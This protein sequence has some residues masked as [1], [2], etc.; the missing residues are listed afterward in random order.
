[1][2]QKLLVASIATGLLLLVSVFAASPLSSGQSA[3]KGSYVSQVKFI[4]YLDENVALGEVKAGKLDTYFYRILPEV[5]SDVKNDS[6]IKIYER[7]A[8]SYGLLLN[9]APAKA[10][11]TSTLNPFQFKQVR[12]AMNYLVDRDFIVNEILRG[13]G[14][15]MVDPFG[16][17]SPEYLNVIGTVE[18]FGFRNDPALAE[19]MI[20]DALI[21][22]GATKD[23]NG[24][25]MFKGKPIT[26][27]ILIRSDDLK[28]KAI[29]ESLSSSL[30]NLGF[31]IQKDYGDLTKASGVVYGSDPQDFQW[32]IYTEGYAGTSAFVKYNPV[33]DAQMYGPWFGNLPG[34]QNTAFWQYQNS[35]LDQLTQKIYLANF[36]SKSERNDLVNAATKQ[37]IQESVRIFL[38]QTREPFVASSSLK[39]LVNDFGAGITSRYSLIN[40]R[41][42]NSNDSLSVGMKQIYQTAWNNVEGCKDTFCVNILAAVEDGSTTRHPYTGEILPLRNTWNNQDI[43]TRGPLSKLDV[44]PDAQI[45]DPYSEQWKAVGQNVTSKSK[46]TYT[47]LYS[48]WHNGIMMDKNDLLYSYYFPFEWSKKNGTSIDPEYAAQA[49]VGIPLIKGIKFLADDKYVSYLD[50]WHYDSKEIADQSSVWSVEPWEITAATERLVKDGKIA[51]SKSQATAKNVDWLSLIVVQHAN[52]IKDELQNMK[53]EGF[54][55]LALKGLVSV[56]DARK[57]YDASISWIQQ[58]QNAL[59]SNG[60]F[61]LDNYNPSGGTITIKAFRDD[62]YP[63]EQGH[64]SSFENPKLATIQNV[65]VPNV[66][67]IGQPST[68]RAN[69][70][71]NGQPSNDAMVNY[72]ISNK[73]GVVVV[74]GLAQPAS[75]P[76][77]VG[78]FAATVQAN[79]TSKLSAG[80]NVLKLFAYGNEALK[81]D[82]YSSTILAAA[83]TGTNNSGSTN[84]NNSST[85]QSQSGSSQTKTGQPSRCLIATAA[86]GSDLAPEVQYLRNFRENY[87]LNTK[88]G[89]AF[90]NT[91]NAVYYSFSPQV[92]DYE[93]G[94]PWM[95]QTVRTALY[96]LFGILALSEKAHSSVNGGEIGAVFAGVV[97]SSLIATVY[98]APVTSFVSPLNRRFTPKIFKIVLSILAATTIAMICGIFAGNNLSLLSLSTAAF[99]VAIAALST[100]AV[101]KGIVILSRSQKTRTS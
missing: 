50:F 19:K 45:W 96:P 8:G 91:F 92:A 86:F 25:W 58:H 99:V 67:T 44:Q 72:F 78:Q 68:I 11:D 29:G 83:L 75:S 65:D 85:N 20:S 13:Y 4:R 17:Y 81:P 27:K 77:N 60:P 16:V 97:A 59:I 57:R 34:W 69:I 54:I 93:R 47:V 43:V 24:K 62:S 7:V 76:N 55:P 89:S 100:M 5:V 88:A 42:D 98:I 6:R 101:T 94:Q 10:N 23:T 46:V 9:P 84:T 15:P 38:A 12:Y 35:S 41:S 1:M 21:G 40:V 63:F 37:G 71:I 32:Q 61:Y 73:D 30:E 18:S 49:S 36:T 48:K 14:T 26:I 53:N 80:P 3:T 74:H 64:W 90:M 66:M 22:A 56:D 33:V 95:Q 51:Y 2:Q 82:I 52:M 87:I 79:E 39:G 28:R 31:T 70:Q